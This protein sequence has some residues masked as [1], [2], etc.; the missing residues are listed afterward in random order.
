MRL[1]VLGGS[2]AC[3]NPGQGSSSYLLEVNGKRWLLDCGPDTLSELRKHV[4]LDQIDQILIS[5][6][7]A[8]HTLDLIPY[9]YGLKY[10]PGIERVCIP[11]GMPP[12]GTDFLRRVSTAFAAGAEP[13]DTFFSEHFEVTEYDPDQPLTLDDATVRFFRTNHPVPCWAMRIESDE[14]T[15]VYLADTGPQDDLVHIA[16]D[17]DILI[18]EGTMLDAVGV[19]NMIERPHISAEEAGR[20]ARD[21]GAG[22]FV[23]THLWWTI[24][25]ERYLESAHREYP[26]DI[27]LAAPGV[28]V[29]VG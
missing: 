18:C 21:S 7:H 24:G 26:G 23:L 2:A 15:L 11:L 16:R 8:D 22:I 5:H 29:S 10:A 4:E 6:V 1:T 9:R 20:I 25:F 19:E 17:A 27:V 28:Q 14:G 3:P 13:A 12:D